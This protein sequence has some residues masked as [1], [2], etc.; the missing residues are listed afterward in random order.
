M[1]RRTVG[2]EVTTRKRKTKRRLDPSKEMLVEIRLP[3]GTHRGPFT[4][5]QFIEVERKR[6]FDDFPDSDF[7]EYREA[8][9]DA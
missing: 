3:D 6:F 1:Y 8:R 2:S 9:R 7:I 4:L 5:T